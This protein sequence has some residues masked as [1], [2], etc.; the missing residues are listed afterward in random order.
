MAA[1]GECHPDSLALGDRDVAGDD[2]TLTHRAEGPAAVR[3]VVEDPVRPE[4]RS[5]A[6]ALVIAAE[7]S[8]GHRAISWAPMPA[9][10]GLEMLVPS[11]IVP[12]AVRTLTAGAERF[13][14][15]KS[16]CGF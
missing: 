2:L 7:A 12:F 6:D 8:A 1:P 14:L 13:G 11:P 5:A 15:L 10:I 4:R 9:T 16:P 3:T